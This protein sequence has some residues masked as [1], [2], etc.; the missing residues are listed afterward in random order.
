MQDDEAAAAIGAVQHYLEEEARASQLASQKTEV[1]TISPWL[2]SSR[3]LGVSQSVEMPAGRGRAKL[4][5]STLLALAM[6]FCMQTARAQI[7]E[8]TSD[9]T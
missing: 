1:K 5:G 4:W 3:E 2:K 9:T 6:S 8:Y 7:S